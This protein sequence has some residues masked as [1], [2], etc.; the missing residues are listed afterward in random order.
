MTFKQALER[1]G[2]VRSIVYS[3]A[4]AALIEGRID[5]AWARFV[6]PF[7]LAPAPLTLA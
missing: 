2:C 7:T 6:R 4:A 1:G 5:A 3:F